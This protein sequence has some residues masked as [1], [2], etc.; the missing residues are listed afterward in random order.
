MTENDFP[1]KYL[2][3]KHK[4]RISRRCFNSRIQFSETSTICKNCPS[5]KQCKEKNGRK[6]RN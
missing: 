3:R 6:I 1:I 4:R 5:Y 2:R